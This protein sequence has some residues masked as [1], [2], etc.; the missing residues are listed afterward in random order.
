MVLPLRRQQPSIG[1]CCWGWKPCE[2]EPHGRDSHRR[3][4]RCRWSSRRR[5]ATHALCLCHGARHPLI[6][7]LY[8]PLLCSSDTAC[9][10]TS[11][12][13]SRCRFP[14]PV[15]AVVRCWLQDGSKTAFDYVRF[16]INLHQ[17]LRYLKLLAATS[18]RRQAVGACNVSCFSMQR[19]CEVVFAVEVRQ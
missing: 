15:R 16:E 8:G 5:C 6:L 10:K 13:G 19:H 3:L 11:G 4:A 18:V 12:L 14:T 1:A 17:A 2:T 9:A 7:I